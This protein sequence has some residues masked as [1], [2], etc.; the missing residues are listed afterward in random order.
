[1]VTIVCYL[2]N[3]M[4]SRLVCES[5]VYYLS[6]LCLQKHVDSNADITVSC[7]PMDDRFVISYF[8]PKFYSNYVDAS[9]FCT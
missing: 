2:L 3:S 9:K 8:F 4:D 7:I 5:F 6:K 1:M